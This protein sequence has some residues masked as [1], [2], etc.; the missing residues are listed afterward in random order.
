MASTTQI[1]GKAEGEGDTIAEVVDGALKVT[2]NG[3]PSDG[4]GYTLNSGEVQGNTSATAFPSLAGV[5]WFKIKAAYDNAGRVSIG[6][7]SGLTQ[8]D[9]TSDVTTG[10]QLS[11]GEETPWI[12][13]GG[14][15]MNT[16]YRRCTNAGDDVVYLA[17]T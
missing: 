6:F 14:A 16:V 3:S 11:A 12:P 5:K 8:A 7:T 2:T 4:A 1:K 15:N 13:L 17:L 9:G 10:W